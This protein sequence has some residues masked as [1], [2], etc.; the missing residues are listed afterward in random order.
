MTKLDLIKEV[1]IPQGVQV[2]IN[3]PLIEA[4]GEKGKLSK[5]FKFRKVI[6]EKKENKIILTMEMLS[7]M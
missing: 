2:T 1:E 7:F 6:I 3:L 4:S 5:E